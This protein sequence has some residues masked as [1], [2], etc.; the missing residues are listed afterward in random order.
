MWGCILRKTVRSLLVV[1]LS[2]TFFVSSPSNSFA[3]TPSSAGSSNNSLYFESRSTNL[4]MSPGINVGTQ[5]FT[6][7]S[8]FKTGP[9]INYGFFLGVAGGNGISIN[10]QSASEIQV[11]AYGINATVFILTNPL[12]VNTWHHIAVARDANNDETVWVDGVRA[13]SSKNRWD[14]SPSGAV[15]RDTRNY[16]GQSTGINVSTG[17]GHCNDGP[18]G[19]STNDFAETKITNYRFIVGSTIYD[20]N[21]STITLPVTPLTN[22]ANTKVLLNVSNLAGLIT[23]SSGNQT[24]TNNSVVFRSAEATTPSAPSSLTATAGNGEATVSFTAGSDGGSA[25]TNYKYSTDGTTFTSFSPAQTTSPITITGLT[26]GTNYSIYLK[27]VNSVGDGTASSAVSVTPVA[28]VVASAPVSTTASAQVLDISFQNKNG[29]TTI[30]W[31]T[32]EE[33]FL[34]IYN[35]TTK[36]SLSKVISG[37]TSLLTNPKPGQST[38]V[39]LKNSLGEIVE[40]FTVN[41]KPDSPKNVSIRRISN[42]LN[43]NW[44]KTKGAKKY[45]VLIQPQ[46]GKQIVLITTD[47]NISVDIS[48][49]AKVKIEIAAIGANG[50]VSKVFKKS[51]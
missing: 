23:D 17:C 1:L 30:T 28:P 16:S 10:I 35:K 21:N 2:F 38:N 44:N 19:N 48:S 31:N 24:L 39:T 47:P 33:L 26:N 27:A 25:I 12:Q 18:T 22:V 29:K 4:I 15:F 43:L 13:A 34:T 49:S 9:A 46:V 41:A 45:R 3:E 37:G 36:K 8:Y 11:D 20:P 6:F 51:L 50:L 32:G 40:S 14:N 7:E 42:T 5:A